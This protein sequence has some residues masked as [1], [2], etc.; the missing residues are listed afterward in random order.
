[1]H[2][3]QGGTSYK[4]QGIEVH[5]PK[6]P[7]NRDISNN[8]VSPMKQRWTRVEL[9]KF[10]AYEIDI[11]S[12]E[13]Y[14]AYEEITWEDARREEV[15]KQ[16]GFDP[17]A[18]N[19]GKNPKPVPGIEVDP[20][21][22]SEPLDSFREAELDKVL[23][24]TWFFNY[25]PKT[26]KSEATYITGR[27]YF[28]LNYWKMDTGYPDYRET[29]RDAFYL[30][31]YAK[32]SPVDFGLIII[33]KRGFGKSYMM[34]GVAYYETITTPKG[35]AGIQ[36]KSEPSAEELFLNKIAEPYKDLPDFLIPINKH[37]DNPT[38]S[39]NFSPLA[40]RS[41]AGQWARKAQKN[42]LRSKLD[43]RQSGETAYDGTTL[44]FY[45]SDE[46]GKT[47]PKIADIEE[48]WRVVRQ[49][50]YR[51][52]VKR[53]WALHTTTVEK[54][55]EGGEQTK[56]LWYDSDHSER[57]ENGRTKSW[58]IRYFISALDNSYFDEYGRPDRERAR[59]EHDAE[60][61]V[62]END[63]SALV[64]YIQKNPYTI[65]EA[66]MTTGD[67]C[68]Y[69]AKI[70]QDRQVILSSPDCTDYRVGDFVW[71]EVDR[72][73]KFVDNPVNGKWH[74]SW[75]FPN[76][77]DAN[78]VERVEMFNSDRYKPLNEDKFSAGFD[79]VSHKRVVVD[80]KKSFAAGTIYK[81]FDYFSDDYYNET[82]CA[83]YLHRP[84]DPTSAFED[85]IIAAFY[86]GVPVLIENNKI[87]AIDHFNRRGYYDFIMR[88]PESTF[89]TKKTKSYNQDTEGMPSNTNIIDHYT[90]I[91][92]SHIVKNG[93]K[94]KHIRVVKDWLDFDPNKT[95]MYDSGVAASFSLVAAT[96]RIIGNQ[97][98]ID[99]S[100]MFSRNSH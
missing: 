21:Y 11:F 65:D 80:K 66:F 89:T 64:S 84:P 56:S 12:G 60:R 15:I 18:V 96:K 55:E 73:A 91:T 37:G 22:V 87:S 98:S 52:S 99:V 24:G 51:S 77:E 6:K 31:E 3:P 23:K 2:Q 69:D 49:C 79:P 28:Y 33:G 4:I 19:S 76:P 38:K 81:K 50:V 67:K 93:H 29:D 54:L 94:L 32:T 57:S 68:V 63:P 58:L 88:R 27:Y 75:L 46:I 100:S 95:T 71:D 5:L 48:R 74:V 39:L 43:Y 40:Q 41:K 62:L 30:M 86:Y 34:G 20:D 97:G 83:D 35:H 70:L 82:I 25:N 53:G 61:K 42:A 8:H 92:A 17:Y 26:K 85:M 10:K 72:K 45:G 16:T 13:D 1:M 44:C 14:D 36:S 7:F 90:N 59:K 47:P 9:P 78:N